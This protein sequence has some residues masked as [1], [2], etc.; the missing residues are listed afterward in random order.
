MV[1]QLDGKLIVV[2]DLNKVNETFR[3]DIA[4]LNTN[5]TPDQTFVSRFLD[6]FSL[7]AIAQ[8]PDGKLLVSG[9]F[10]SINDFERFG[11]ARL[12]NTQQKAVFADFDGDGK[13]DIAVFRDGA[14]YLMQS[15]QGFAAMQF[16]VPGDKPILAANAR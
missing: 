7:Y 8:Q 1:L 4:R 12:L 9:D 16:G 13:T 3:T 5:G 14:W 10:R 6:S 2:G 15:Q 11:L